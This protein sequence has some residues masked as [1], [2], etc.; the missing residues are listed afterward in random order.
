M[1]IRYLTKPQAL[2]LEAKPGLER[3]DG[4]QFALTELMSANVSLKNVCFADDAIVSIT[5]FA[6]EGSLLMCPSNASDDVKRL[7]SDSRGFVST[8]RST[9]A[10]A[11]F[12]TDVYPNQYSQKHQHIHSIYLDMDGVVWERESAPN[13]LPSFAMIADYVKN[14]KGPFTDAPPISIATGADR[15]AF[16][17]CLRYAPIDKR[18]IPSQ[19]HRASLP[20]GYPPIIFEE[21]YLVFDPINEVFYDLTEEKYGLVSQDTCALLRLIQALGER[22]NERVPRINQALGANCKIVS[23]ERA[24]YTLDL[25]LPF[26]LDHKGA[27]HAHWV[28]WCHINDILKGMELEFG[29]LLTQKELQHP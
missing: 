6:K 20:L 23:K 14:C 15:N 29:G 25:P 27:E 3:N 10:V 13:N 7:V 22:I 18:H 1:P 17:D 19:F 2:C 12:L 11:E 24:G 5:P 16:L 9:E 26:K 4:I 28:I 8:K 21:G